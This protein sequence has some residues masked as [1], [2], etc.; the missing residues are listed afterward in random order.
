MI[1][2]LNGLFSALLLL[3]FMP[4]LVLFL[5]VL[6]LYLWLVPDYLHC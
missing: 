6:F 1:I 3:I 2:F 4:V 5:Q